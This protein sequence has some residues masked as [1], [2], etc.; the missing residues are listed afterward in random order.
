MVCSVP[1]LRPGRRCRE[2]W[3][4]SGRSGWRG[5]TGL[6]EATDCSRCAVGSWRQSWWIERAEE[7]YSG[8]SVSGGLHGERV[9]LH[10]CM[11]NQTAE[12]CVGGTPAEAVEAVLH[13]LLL[14]SREESYMGDVLLMHAAA[15]AAAAIV[16]VDC[17]VGG[18]QSIS[19]G[20]DF[21]LR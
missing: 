15:S 4:Q 3:C 13:I 14:G 6:Q 16:L 10:R 1:A 7:K 18:Q 19:F 8:S 11:L 12:C 20:A 5:R 17:V 21:C 9:V 2:R